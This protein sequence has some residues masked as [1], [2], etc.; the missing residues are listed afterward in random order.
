M[1]VNAPSEKIFLLARVLLMP[2]VPQTICHKGESTLF[3]PAG[4]ITTLVKNGGAS[5]LGTSVMLVMTI[6]PLN[7]ADQD[8]RCVWFTD[9]APRDAFG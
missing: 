4:S 3:K 8:A 6:M 1:R 2:F 9:N 7:T 5:K